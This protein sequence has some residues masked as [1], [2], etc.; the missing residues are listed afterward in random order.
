MLYFCFKAL[1]MKRIGIIGAGLKSKNHLKILSEIP[2]LKIVG[3]YDEDHTEALKLSINSK[4]SFFKNAYELLEEVDAVDVTTHE[5]NHFD[6]IEKAIKGSRHVFLSGP[7]YFPVKKL[8]FLIKLANEANIRLQI[9]K[10]KRFSPVFESARPLIKGARII[11]LNYDVPIVTQGISLTSVSSYLSNLLEIIFETVRANLKKL[12]ALSITTGD[13][14]MSVIHARLE[15]ENSSVSNI[16]INGFTDKENLTGKFY[17]KK[18]IVSLDLNSEEIHVKKIEN[19]KLEHVIKPV[20]HQSPLCQELL[21]FISEIENN[22]HTFASNEDEIKP[23][24]VTDEILE[25]AKF[26]AI[27]T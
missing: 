22:S 15:F 11:E 16:N 9:E 14:L 4:I 12:S 26:R 1:I 6:L 7:V 23:M 5:N 18:G 2:G 21:N 3:I 19:N 25:K 13:D 8:I 17:T 10:N 27:R 24:V 20:I